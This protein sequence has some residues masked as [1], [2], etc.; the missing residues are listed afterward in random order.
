MDKIPTTEI[1][2]QEGSMN[3]S[4]YLAISG[5]LSKL[6]FTPVPIISNIKIDQSILKDTPLKDLPVN[7][8]LKNIIR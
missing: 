3:V 4:F 1:K 2:R 8:L 6:V 7:D 5:P